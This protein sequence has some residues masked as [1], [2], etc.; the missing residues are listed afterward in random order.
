MAKS[1]VVNEIWRLYYEGYPTYKIAE[2][3]GTTEA[4]VVQV[5]GL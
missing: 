3:T 4:Y 1:G 5:L 2:M